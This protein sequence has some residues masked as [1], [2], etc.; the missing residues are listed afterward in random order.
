ML[1]ARLT[2]GC[3]ACIA[4]GLA[5]P[6]A[7]LPHPDSDFEDYQTRIASFPK[8][9]VEASAFEA[10]PPPTQAVE[11]LYYGACLIELA[12]GNVDKVFN[13]YTIT[14]YTPEGEGGKLSLSVQPLAVENAAPPK[15]VAKAGAVGSEILGPPAAVDANG[16]Y[17]ADLGTVNVPGTANP[18]SGSDAVIEVAT[19]EGRFSE[20][21][22]CA[23]LGGN[24]TKPEAAARTLD[25]TQNICQ[26]V[27]IK[28]GDPTPK[29]TTADFQADSC[30]LQ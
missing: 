5:A 1:G 8:P 19:M 24:V 20:A 22:F 3:L 4:V 2:L 16:K 27:P 12:F 21:K 17:K 28:D 14:K 23:R 30:P 18:I 13:F 6:W 11:G 29:F 7:C 9:I 25:P 10:A 26:F 15:N